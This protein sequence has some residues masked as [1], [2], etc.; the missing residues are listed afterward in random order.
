MR[1]PLRHRAV[2]SVLVGF[3]STSEVD[4]NV[5]HFNTEIE[6]SS[7][8]SLVSVLSI[9]YSI[10][11]TLH[12]DS[13][14]FLDLGAKANLLGISERGARMARINSHVEADIAGALDSTLSIRREF[15]TGATADI[16]VAIYT[17]ARGR[18]LYAFIDF[19]G[20]IHGF[21]NVGKYIPYGITIR[22]WMAEQ[23]NA[24]VRK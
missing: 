21:F 8:G 4:E 7:W 23:I 5:K 22:E 11:M 17:P 12:S 2:K 9:S 3:R 13:Q 1:F 6:A 15:F 16:P 10:F 24:L 19:H 18:S 14:A 20:M